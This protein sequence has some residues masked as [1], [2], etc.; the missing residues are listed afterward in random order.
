[1][2]DEYLFGPS[3]IA[4]FAGIEQ[5]VQRDWRRRGILPSEDVP[6][7]CVRNT[8]G[9]W[10]FTF[11]GIHIAYTIRRF[12]EIGFELIDA[13][14]IAYEVVIASK[15]Y[16]LHQNEGEIGIPNDFRRYLLIYPENSSENPSSFGKNVL[17]KWQ[18]ERVFD[19]NEGRTDR[20]DF[21]HII[22]LI[23]LSNKWAEFISGTP[24]DGTQ[25]LGGFV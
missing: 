5:N 22:D 24:T 9:R 8:S 18:F 6:G 17:R 19:L 14:N 12:A 1:M 25:A 7:V 16:L 23:A 15:V 11:D 2:T 21:L 3:D 4:Q 20:P 13:H 10:R